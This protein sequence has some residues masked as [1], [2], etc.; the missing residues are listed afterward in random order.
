M[1]K[2][3]LWSFAGDHDL[4]I[5]KISEN[6]DIVPLLWIL[7]SI[8]VETGLKVCPGVDFKKNLWTK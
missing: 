1:L 2:K 3:H 6:L 5:I 7:A 8:E 4:P